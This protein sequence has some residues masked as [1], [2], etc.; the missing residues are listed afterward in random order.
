MKY[1]VYNGIKITDDYSLFEFLSIGQN[2]T[3]TKRIEFSPTEIPG[4]FNLS[5]G[6]VGANGEI[7][8]TKVS[9]NGDR[10]KVLATV[11]FAVEIYLD[12]Y[13][14]RYIYFSGSTKERTRLYRM[15]IGLNLEELATKFEIYAELQNGIVP[16]QKNMEILALII[17]KKD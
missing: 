9:D 4:V 5:F 16:F 17:R 11:A 13:P 2:G 3:I 14:D 15:A 1:E 12:K 7:D 8:D 10:N 6:D